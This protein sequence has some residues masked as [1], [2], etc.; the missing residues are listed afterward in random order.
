VSAT[1]DALSRP[2]LVRRGLALDW[3]T[4]AYDVVE[5]VVAI[6]AGV[7]A[8]SVALLGFGLRDARLSGFR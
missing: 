7:V 8:G 1:S 5:A 3:L 6:G 2:A 4:I